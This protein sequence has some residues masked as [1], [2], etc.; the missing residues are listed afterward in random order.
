MGRNNTNR[1]YNIHNSKLAN[2]TEVVDLGV[3]RFDKHINT[4]NSSGDEIAN[5]NS[6]RRH[7]TRTKIQ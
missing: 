2:A 4:R 1:E 7:C 5:V 3:M 6:L